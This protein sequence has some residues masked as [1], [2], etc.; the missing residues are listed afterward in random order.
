MNLQRVIGKR[1]PHD[2]LMQRAWRNCREGLAIC[3]RDE[4]AWQKA[5]EFSVRAKSVAPA[6]MQRWIEIL[7][8][9][10]AEHVRALF[11]GEDFFTL[12]PQEQAWWDQL[13][14]SAPFA[15]VLVKQ[16]AQGK[17]QREKRGA[18]AHDSGAI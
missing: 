11:A 7:N 17:E 3:R 16:S 9:D 14:Q 10:H 12:T 13:I 1:N 4:A 6:H 5:L 15:P 2:A 8:G 18:N